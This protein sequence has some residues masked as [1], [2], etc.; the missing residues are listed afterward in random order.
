M[1]HGELK[2]IRITLAV[3]WIVTGL[4]S[5]G[6]Y[7][8]QHSLEL[9]A[10]LSLNDTS[11]RVAL[12]LAAGLNIILGLLTLFIT[13]KALWLFQALLVLIYTLL[14]TLWLPE[15]WLHPF[16]PILKNLA[17]LTLLW[18]LYRSVPTTP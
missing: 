5:L 6:I 12:Y 4:L 15:Y 3:I 8:E 7:P 10:R 14:I 11:A 9:L 16:G 1:T 17:V 18:L 13:K 2:I